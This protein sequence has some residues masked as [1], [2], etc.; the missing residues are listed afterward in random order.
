M[1]DQYTTRQRSATEERT[2]WTGTDADYAPTRTIMSPLDRVRWSSVLAGLFTV[3]ATLIVLAVLGV[4][5]GLSTLDA[6][7]PRAL[8]IGAGIYGAV[9]A[10]IAFAL[11]GYM[12]SRTAAVAGSGNG[13]LNGAM[14]WVVTIPLLVNILGNGVGSLLGTAT[15]LA[16]T[17]VTSAA[18]VAAPAVGQAAQAVATNP[19]AGATAVSGAQGAATAV[20]GAVQDAQTQ[21]QNVS[22]QDVNNTARNLSGPAWTALLALGLSAA[23]AALG[24]FVGRR[25]VPTEIATSR[26]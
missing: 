24:G 22:P 8:G 13:V 17:A 21:L 15:D 19:A 9:S 18:Q 12:A 1:T 3:M 10:L 2:G 16:Q 23:A 25:S 4:A 6:N 14:V 5:I 26:P 11:G 20:Q 7:N